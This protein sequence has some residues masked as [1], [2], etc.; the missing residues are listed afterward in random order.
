MNIFGTRECAYCLTPLK[1]EVS[2][3]LPKLPNIIT[4]KGT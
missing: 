4:A 1:I 2:D 3:A